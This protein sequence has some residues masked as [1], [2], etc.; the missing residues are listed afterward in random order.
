MAVISFRPAALFPAC[1]LVVACF[2][3]ASRQSVSHLPEQSSGCA[4]R[5]CEFS[6]SQACYCA[7]CCS[8]DKK[9]RQLNIFKIIYS[10]I[11]LIDELMPFIM[12]YN[13]TT[14]FAY[15]NRNCYSCGRDLALVFAWGPHSQF[16]LVTCYVSAMLIKMAT[17]AQSNSPVGDWGFLKFLN[18]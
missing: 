2:M 3:H 17:K 1:I 4:L 12:M 13:A 16:A 9:T 6:W 14:S 8:T 15:F 10:Y 11:N 18:R 5:L 7:V